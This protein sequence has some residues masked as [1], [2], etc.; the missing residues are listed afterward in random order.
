[1]LAYPVRLVPTKEGNVRAVF[2]DVPQAVAEGTDEEDALYRAKFVL[3]MCLGHMLAHGEL[4]PPP[5]DICGA[6]TVTTEKFTQ[7]REAA[8]PAPA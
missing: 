6:P 5:S 8:A 1:M 7:V 4:P 2:P 3:E